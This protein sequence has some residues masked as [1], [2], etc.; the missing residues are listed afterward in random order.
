MANR[1]IEP[2]QV[3]IYH[4]EQFNNPMQ[5]CDTC[6]YFK[7][8]PTVEEPTKFKNDGICMWPKW[9]GNQMNR[10]DGCRHWTERK[11]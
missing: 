10:F 3:E 8:H 2:P 5:L 9:V 1:I 4:I 7:V 6:D 11:E